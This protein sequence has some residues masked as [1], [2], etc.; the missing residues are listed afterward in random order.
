MFNGYY[1]HTEF[2]SEVVIFFFNFQRNIILQK[3]KNQS[4]FI[5]IDENDNVKKSESSKSKTQFKN[6]ENMEYC[7]NK[8]NQR[9]YYNKFVIF[10]VF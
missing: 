7:P 10:Y 3:L 2:L 4:S 9:K 6:V 1:V 5:N 8:H